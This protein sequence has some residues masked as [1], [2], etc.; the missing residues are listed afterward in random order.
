M[1]KNLH[2]LNSDFFF[3]SY[4]S[5]NKACTSKDLSVLSVRRQKLSYRYTIWWVLT[6]G[7][8]EGAWK[9]RGKR[10]CIASCVRGYFWFPKDGKQIL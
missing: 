3:L 9:G 1:N 6:M 7:S 10:A 5:N 8:P 4:S 2:D